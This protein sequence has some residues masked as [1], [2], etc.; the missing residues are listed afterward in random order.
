MPDTPIRI[1]VVVPAFNEEHYV[2]AALESLQG[3]ECAPPYEIIVVDNDSSDDTAAV[4]R[5]YGV[6]VLHEPQPGVCAARQ[7]GTAAARG[8]IVVSTDADTV[9]PSDWL[10]RID[11]ELLRSEDAVLVAGPAAT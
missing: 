3:Q 10:A 7:R 4:A 8:D 5:R 11:A 9:H 2:A 6:T 1:S